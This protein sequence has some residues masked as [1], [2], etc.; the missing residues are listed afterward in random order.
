M[1]EETPIDRVAEVIMTPRHE[2]LPHLPF[3]PAIRVSAGADLIF[4]SGVLG[5][6]DRLPGS[7]DP[8]PP[9][10][11][12]VEAERVFTRIADVLAR[13]GATLADVVKVTKYML[14]LEQHP[15]VV[16]VMRKHFGNHLP[17]STTVEVSRLVPKGFGLEVEAIAAVP[18][19]RRP[20]A[21]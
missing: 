17:A 19:G 18:P 20:P 7:D 16:A 12:S 6:P 13:S 11:I 21:A 5:T 3:V 10:D 4:V 1:G 14:D 15:A 9:G 8:S 2:K